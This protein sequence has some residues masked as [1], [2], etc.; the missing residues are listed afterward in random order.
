MGEYFTWVNPKKGEWID[1][2]PFSECG[3]VF[4]VAA[5]LGD[6]YTDAA[7][8]LLAGPWRGDPVMFVGDYFDPGEGSRTGALFDGYPCD[9]IFDNFRNVTGLFKCAEGMLS[10]VFGPSPGDDDVPYEGPFELE[11][12]HYRYAV[13]RTRGEYVD[14]DLGPVRHVCLWHGEYSWARVDPLLPLLT[15]RNA[16]G[17]AEGRWCCDEIEV[18][19]E[20]PFGDWRDVACEACAWWGDC[21]L[22]YATDAEM[23]A[24]IASEEF[25]QASAEGRVKPRGDDSIDLS[26]AVEV[27]R[28]IAESRLPRAERAAPGAGGR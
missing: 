25:A 19:D 27:L 22:L 28:G 8:T 18:A 26:G 6:R 5:C 10:P 2:E 1:H 12:R 21:G 14:R 9:D 20:L 23:Q 24:L 4:N 13:N 7:C 15:P 3:F 11:V 16:G 17:D